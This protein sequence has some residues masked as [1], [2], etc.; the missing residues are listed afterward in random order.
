MDDH[1]RAILDKARETLA[2]VAD[3]RVVRRV[4]RDDGLLTE[5]SVNMPRKPPPPTIDE[6]KQIVSDE[7]AKQ[8]QGM[9]PAD[10]EALVERVLG[11]HL[12]LTPKAIA[13]ILHELRQQL[14][15]E[16]KA[17]TSRPAEEFFYLDDDGKKQDADLHNPILRAVDYPIDEKIMAP[18]RQRH[19]ARYL[20]EQRAKKDR[21]IDLPALPLRGRRA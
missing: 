12:V 6:V 13:P 20:A 19:R 5:H 4:H 21:V 17:H 2:R 15:A 1:A 14:R 18:I 3:V 11:R 10:V 9:T 16:I 8:P 7:L